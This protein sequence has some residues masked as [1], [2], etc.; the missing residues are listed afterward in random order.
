MHIYKF[1]LNL[2]NVVYIFK[3]HFGDSV[4]K[5]N[6]TDVGLLTTTLSRRPPM[7]VNALMILAQ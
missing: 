3:C 6:N 2:T 1:H 5:E 4:S 7:H